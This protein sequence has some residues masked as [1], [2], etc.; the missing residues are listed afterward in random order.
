MGELGR[1]YK[2]GECIVELGEAGDCMFVVQSG[3]VEVVRQQGGQT[4]CLAKLA[5]GEF[6][7]EMALFEKEVRSA[8]VRARGDVRVLTVDKKNLLRRI[9]EDPS[10][11]F[12]MV[13]KMSKRIRDLNAELV[14][15]KLGQ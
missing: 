6:F 7:G 10:L 3:T 9:N 13:Q 11:A 1:L 15:M 4:I 5:E 8:T 2:N 14:R 12:R